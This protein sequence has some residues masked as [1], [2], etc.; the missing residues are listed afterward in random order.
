[1]HLQITDACPRNN[2]PLSKIEILFAPGLLH[3][4]EALV[5][6]QIAETA[7][8]RLTS[9]QPQPPTRREKFGGF[10]RPWFSIGHQRRPSERCGR[11]EAEFAS[12][13]NYHRPQGSDRDGSSFTSHFPIQVFG[14]LSFA[15]TAAAFE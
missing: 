13:R 1:M 5:R 7:D 14:G 8:N 4:K 12:A 6:F 3:G 2:S 9:A 11:S 15:A 10:Q